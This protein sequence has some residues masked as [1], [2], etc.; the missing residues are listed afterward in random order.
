MHSDQEDI[1]TIIEIKQGMV[2]YFT[3]QGGVTV[4][5]RDGN[6]FYSATDGTTAATDFAVDVQTWGATVIATSKKDPTEPGDPDLLQAIT[7][8][9][10]DDA[11]YK[12]LQAAITQGGYR[13]Q[14]N[15]LL[16]VGYTAQQ[17]TDSFYE[18]SGEWTLG[19]INAAIVLADHYKNDSSKYS[20]LI[21]EAKDMM[22]GVTQETSSLQGN[23]KKDS[24]S[25]ISYLYANKRTF[26]PFGWFSNKMPAMASTGWSLMVNS[27]FNPMELGGGNYQSICQQL[28]R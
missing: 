11:M 1:Q 2:K 23:G 13:D 20:T 5:N 14:N 21:A 18:L 19:A 9:Y 12:M 28:T 3:G 6:Y 24:G 7:D 10:G 25:R 15:K 16:G 17:P 8:T 27:C 22:E 26:I 4:F